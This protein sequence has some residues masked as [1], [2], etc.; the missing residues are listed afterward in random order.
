MTN[1]VWLS[2]LGIN[3]KFR[4]WITLLTLGI[5]LYGLYFSFPVSISFLDP[6]RSGFAKILLT[7]TLILSLNWVKKSAF[8]S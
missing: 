5:F 6:V 1:G 2:E 8:V 7:I 4:K 3:A